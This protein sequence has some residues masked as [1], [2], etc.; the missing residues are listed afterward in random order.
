MLWIVAGL[1]V[2]RLLGEWFLSALNRAEVRRHAGSAPPA[3]TAIMEEPTYR[4]SVAYT[5]ERSRSG[6]WPVVIW[7]A[8]TGHAGLL[9]LLFFFLRVSRAKGS[10]L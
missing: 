9:L 6:A 3:V 1:M 4:K 10:D 7:V 5:L 8:F 2:F